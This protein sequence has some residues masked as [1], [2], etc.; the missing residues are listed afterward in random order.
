MRVRR[1]AFLR[2]WALGFGATLML[3]ACGGRPESP[4]G[5]VAGDG[6]D[7]DSPVATLR[8]ATDPTF[9]PFEFQA[10][11]D[12]IQGFDI[13]LMNA[14]G[15]AAGLDIQ[16]AVL[17]FDSIIPALQAGTVD[18]AISAM[19]ITA[20]RLQT[21]AF[22]RPYLKTGLA[23]AV[24]AN[25]N[26]IRSI[27]DLENKTIAVQIGTPGA[28]KAATI[29]GSQLSLFDA[30]LEALQALADGSVD[31]VI[32]DAAVTLAAIATGEV[33]GIAVVGDL[34]TTAFYGI[35]LPKDSKNQAAID[36]AIAQLIKNGTYARIYR[37]WFGTAPPK[38]PASAV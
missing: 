17:P 35:V 26:G 8:V 4:Q 15:A 6:E 27:A 21:V 23:I 24:R 30:A 32:N 20:E 1:S 12:E 11:G 28:D 31:A 18:A 10:N 9:P 38:L 34:L 16:Y 25:N 7:A 19:T 2:R 29:P 37:E 22:S 36:G 3:A 33:E 14:I 13:D 5:A